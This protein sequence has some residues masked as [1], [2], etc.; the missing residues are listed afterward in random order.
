MT[1]DPAKF[2]VGSNV[3]I[4]DRAMLEEFMANW[5]LHHK[6]TAR[7]IRYAGKVVKVKKNYMYHGGDVLYE[8]K[9]APGI[10]HEW[11]LGQASD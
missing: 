9:G 4:A 8:L 3:R 5:T 1:Y 2:P 7:Q 6:L 11:C 10:W